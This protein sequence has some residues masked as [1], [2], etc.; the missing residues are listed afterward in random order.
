MACK[1]KVEDHSLAKNAFAQASIVVLGTTQDAGS[2]QIGCNKA[3]CSDINENRMVASLGLI[4]PKDHSTFV[5][6]AT[7]DFVH[8]TRLLKDYC[9][10]PNFGIPDAIFLTHAH[11][12]HYTGLMYLGKEALAAD[13]LKVFCMPRMQQFLNNNG[14]WD[15]MVKEGMIHPLPQINKKFLPISESISIAPI[16]VPHRDEYSE[17]VGYLVKGPNK[18]ALYIPDIDK[19]SVWD[20][21]I[22][23]WIHQVD[24]AILDATFFNGSELPNRDISAVP[25]PFVV[26][27]MELFKQL[28]PKDREK[29]IFT[30]FNHTNPLLD[31]TSLESKQVT[32]AGFR[33][34]ELG[35]VLPL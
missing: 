31:N 26:E 12:G 35:M 2:P 32:D 9:S 8:Q 15:I 10:F 17:T 33:L 13:S 29:V 7:P 21:S 18:L 25:H 14:P 34:A 1:Q 19:W 28:D 4:D 23:A 24:Y 5:I 30:H 11:I 20:E 6:D 16:T 3:C 27:S 22:L